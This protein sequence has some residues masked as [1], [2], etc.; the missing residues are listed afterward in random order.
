MGRRSFQRSLQDMDDPIRSRNVGIDDE[1]VVDET[2][3]LKRRNGFRPS[4]PQ[5]ERFG[6]KLQTELVNLTY[7]RCSHLSRRVKQIGDSKDRQTANTGLD[8]AAVPQLAKRENKTL[9]QV[10]LNVPL[11]QS[12]WGQ[13]GENTEGVV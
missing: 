6:S 10:E 9:G 1:A 4:D 2:G 3:S 5:Q 12:L 11:G 13:I 7:D 8:A